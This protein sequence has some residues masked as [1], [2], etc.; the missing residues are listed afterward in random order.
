M[1]RRHNVKLGDCLSSIA[2]NTGFFADTLWQ[3]PDN[4][5]LRAKPGGEIDHPL[6]PRAVAGVLRVGEAGDVDEYILDLGHLE[7]ADSLPGVRQRLTNLGVPCGDERGEL[8]PDI[9]AAIGDFQAF[10]GLTVTG[11]IDVAHS[12]YFHHAP[13]LPAPGPSCTTAGTSV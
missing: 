9:R 11:R 8:G 13:G 2:F 10:H 12:L 4:R 7:P 6:S 3:H 1:P 5:Q